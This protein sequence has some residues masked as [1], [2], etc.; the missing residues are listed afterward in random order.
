MSLTAA[1]KQGKNG[2]SAIKISTPKMLVR[3][4]VDDPEDFDKDIGGQGK[5][6]NLATVV[7]VSA[8]DLLNKGEFYRKQL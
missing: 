3:K 6:K 7:D 8:D 2:T 4:E 1:L 5:K